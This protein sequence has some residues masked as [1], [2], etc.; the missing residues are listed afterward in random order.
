MTA[1]VDFIC[2]VIEKYYVRKLRSFAN[3]REAAP[4]FL[5]QALLKKAEY[6][7]TD[8]IL[9]FTESWRFLYIMKVLFFLLHHLNFTHFINFIF[10]MF[11][12]YFYAY[13][14]WPTSS[15]T[16]FFTRLWVN[17]GTPL[18]AG[19]CPRT[20]SLP[21]TRDG[22]SAPLSPLWASVEESRV[23]AP[24][25]SR[26]VGC[27]KSKSRACAS[28]FV[29]NW[30]EMVRRHLECWGLPSVS[31]VWAALAFSNGTRDL[32]YLSF[33]IGFYRLTEYGMNI[34]A[35]C[36]GTDLHDHPT[37]QPLYEVCI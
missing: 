6:L 29:W 34:I 13:K 20:P 9:N 14:V 27:R 32:T 33:K 30:E 21:G 25:C 35:E 12:I 36:C 23:S 15:E 2:T 19:W 10:F 31:S 5:L 28:N 11:T 22:P 26:R 7:N 4:R 24:Y 3:S 18:F 1:L 37:L 17:F 8:N 16:D